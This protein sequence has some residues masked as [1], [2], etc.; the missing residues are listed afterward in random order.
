M[1]DWRFSWHVQHTTCIQTDLRMYCEMTDSYSVLIGRTFSHYRILK[2]LGAGGMGVVYEAEDTS[3]GRHVALKFLPD[4]LALDSQAL[5]RFRRE[6]RAASA[7]NHPNICTIHDIGEVDGQTFLVMELLDGL[8]LKQL[9]GGKP[10]QAA[11]L[12]DFACQITD[13]LRAAHAKGII[14][15]DIK[16]ANIFIT[17]DGQAKLLDFGLAKVIHS[18]GNIDTTTTIDQTLTTV[19]ATVGTVAYMSPEQARGKELDIRTDIFSFGAVLYEMGTG[20][21]PF[22]GD[23][24]ADIFDGLLNR[25]PAAPVQLNPALPAQLGNIVNKALQKEPDQRYQNAAEMRADLQQLKRAM[26]SPDWNETLVT[27]HFAVTPQVATPSKAAA[28]TAGPAKGRRFLWTGS[29]A[30][31]ALALVIAGWLFL[32]RHAHALTEKDTVVL[33]DFT[34]TTGDAIFEDALRQGLA[35]QLEQSPFLSLVSD[36]RIAQTLGLMTKP[37]DSRLGHQL[38]REVCLRMGSKATIEGAISGLGGPYELRMKVVDCHSGDVLADIKES[39]GGRDQVLPALGKAATRLREKLGESLATVQKYDVPAENV[40]TGSLEALQA[41]SQGYRAMNVSADWK[42]SIALFEEA[43]SRDPNFA[44]AYARLAMNYRNTSDSVKAAE[45]ARRAYDLRQRVSERERFYIESTYEINVTENY[46][47]ARKIYEAWEQAYQREDVA[48]SVTV[49][50]T[51]G[52]YE[53]LLSAAQR[54]VRLDPESVVGYGN[55][56]SAYFLL[57]RFDEAKATLQE[58]QAHHLEFYNLHLGLYLIGFVEHDAAGMERETN[59]LMSKPGH[60]DSM[61]YLESQTAAYGGQMSRARELADRVAE[62]TQRLGRK[63]SA[64]G[65]LAQ[66]ALR[67]ALVGNVVFARRQAENALKLTDNQYVE[68]MAAV[69]LGLTGDS[70]KATRMAEDLARRFPQATSI[71]LH[72]LPMIHGASAMQ[73]GKGAEAVQAFTAA[74]PYELGSPRW[75]NYIRLYPVYLHG[76][77]CLAARQSAQAAAEFQ[78][79]LDHPGIVA[80]EPIGSLAHLGLGRAYGMAG[81]HAKAKTAYQDFLG[82]WKDA[83]PDVPILIA[84][85]SEYA[86]LR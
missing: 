68:A 21:Q 38:A 24:T 72:Y 83:D 65:F 28:Q 4:V 18:A 54:S 34:N 62:D 33:A 76:Q 46:E 63:D 58:A 53:K 8:N 55:L 25:A 44:M 71:Q 47:S 73:S 37:K 14:H 43:T 50:Q 15:R 22:R 39:A 61:L 26:E 85:K 1:P 19:G 69:V 64:G 74:E 2:K 78:K 30:T 51:L 41:Y 5:E 84:A 6:A 86:K 66:A 48:N 42:N 13:A 79:I 11:V 9:I 80:N 56:S 36:D 49:Y 12:L 59:Y 77:A 82:L 57:G 10:L 32:P 27:A 16:P 70:A 31:L 45:N 52:D 17:G 75:M 40:T 81:D 20:V 35:S 60:E 67:E 3:L 7:L 23:S 29:A